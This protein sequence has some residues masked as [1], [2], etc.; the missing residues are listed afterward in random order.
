M[1]ITIILRKQL[2]HIILPYV[3]Q[4][5]GVSLVISHYA[6]HNTIN[7]LCIIIDNLVYSDKL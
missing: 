3:I 4:F 2:F 7:A 6:S 1:N 5:T